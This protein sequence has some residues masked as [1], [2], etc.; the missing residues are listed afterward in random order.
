MSLF[1]VLLYVHIACGATSLLLG[2]FILLS[3]KGTSIHKRVGIIYYYCMLT[4]ALIS[5]PMSYLHSNYFLFIIGVFTSYLL[6]TGKRSLKKK[7]VSDAQN[8]DWALTIVMLIFGVLFIVFGSYKLTHADYFGIVFLV[9]GSISIFFVCQDKRNFTGKSRYKNYWLTTHIQR[10]V[11]SYIATVTAF[12]VVNN[13]AL[14]D[15]IAW[16][17]PTVLLVPLIVKWMIKYSIR[18]VD[19]QQNGI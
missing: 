11:A 6:L 15:T 1:N 5:F 4:A 10:M 9:F 13:K 2:L 7:E 16:L 19:R 3:K 18:A 12:L 8:M 17:L 14:P